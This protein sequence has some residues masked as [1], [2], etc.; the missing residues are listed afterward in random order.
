MKKTTLLFVAVLFLV[1]SFATVAVAGVLPSPFH[2]ISAISLDVKIHGKRLD[3]ILDRPICDSPPREVK[4]AV[5]ELHDIA[6][7]LG[8]S[9]VLVKG[10]LLGST[11]C[12]SRLLATFILTVLHS[13]AQ[14]SGSSTG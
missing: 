9:S 11:W 7:R 12:K 10:S 14:S 4:R 5:V 3:E 6:L 1:G 2:Q 13:R 8:G